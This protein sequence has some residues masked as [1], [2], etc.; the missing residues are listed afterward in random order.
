MLTGA[1]FVGLFPSYIWLDVE[2]SSL[3]VDS[4]PIEIGWCA[5]DLV[6]D[7]FL[8]KPLERWTDWSIASE[9]IHGIQLQELFDQGIDAA[10]AAREINR[11]CAGKQVLSDNPVSDGD[12]LK[13]LFHDTG[14][15]QEFEL[16]DS[17]QLE[18]MAAALSK[19]TPAWAQ[20]LVEQINGRFP[21]PHRAGPDARREVARFLALVLPEEVETISALA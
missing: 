21:H 14:V 17:R 4:F 11:I 16:H 13:Q 18:A 20:S 1:E 9:L 12:W 6:A 19:L 2:A 15:R 8:V 7:S 3:S 5:A 10:E